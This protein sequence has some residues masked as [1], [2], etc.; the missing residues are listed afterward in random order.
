ME[1]IDFLMKHC[2]LKNLLLVFQA[3][4]EKQS[5]C[6]L[7]THSTDANRVKDY[8]ATNEIDECF[9]RASTSISCLQYWSSHGQS[10]K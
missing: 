1:E 3:I 7:N 9:T 2:C 10:K 5:E 4:H 6:S 8:L